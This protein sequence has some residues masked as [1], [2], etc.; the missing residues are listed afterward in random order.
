MKKFFTLLLILSISCIF[1]SSCDDIIDDDSFNERYDTVDFPVGEN[2][3]TVDVI[4]NTTFDAVLNSVKNEDIRYALNSI[5]P[6]SSILVYNDE[7]NLCHF[8]FDELE[9]L[10]R[11]Y[12]WTSDYATSKGISV[13]MT[14]AEMREA[15]GGPNRIEK[16]HTPGEDIDL[17]DWTYIYGNLTFTSMHN[18]KTQEDLPIYVISY[19]S[20]EFLQE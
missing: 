4:G 3:L 10:N 1:L 19:L 12:I 16:V 17:D 14:V 7:L 13:G 2:K 18:T 9:K 15:Y 20:N 5:H 8:H 6:K 11:M